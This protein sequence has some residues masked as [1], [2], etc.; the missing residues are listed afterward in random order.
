MKLRRAV[1]LLNKADNLG[2]VWIDIHIQL[3]YIGGLLFISKKSN[4]IKNGL[5]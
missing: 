5:C 4:Y 1:V 3:A 2:G